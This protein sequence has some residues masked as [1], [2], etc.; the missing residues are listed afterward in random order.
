M[1]GFGIS[2]GGVIWVYWADLLPD[3]GMAFCLMMDYLFALIIAQLPLIT[4]LY[5]I[6]LVC[7]LIGL[8]F[9]YFLLIETKG[10][11]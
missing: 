6:Y 3:N 7:S 8:V 4:E 10:K 5:S 1:L 9:V 2:Y 11:S